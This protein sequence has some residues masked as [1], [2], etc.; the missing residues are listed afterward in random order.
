[1]ASLGTS[2]NR[3]PFKRALCS[4]VWW[5]EDGYRSEAP[6]RQATR[7]GGKAARWSRGT[8][9]LDAARKPGSTE[10][11]SQML[12]RVDA[13]ELALMGNS[14]AVKPTEHFYMASCQEVLTHF[15]DVICSHGDWVNPAYPDHI[16]CGCT[17]Q[18]QCLYPR[19]HLNHDEISAQIVTPGGT[20]MDTGILFEWP[21]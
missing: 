17:A 20:L 5:P 10:S 9:A 14:D 3:Y 15:T 7:W 1:M 18:L 4:Q 16:S 8:W 6:A 11:I 19:A 12:E 21:V 13:D 2:L